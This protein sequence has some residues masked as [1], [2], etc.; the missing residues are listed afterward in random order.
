MMMFS[1]TITITRP[2][3]WH[4]HLRDGEP[5]SDVITFSAERFGRALVMP[6]LTPPVVTVEMATAYRN[7]ILTELHI[8]RL[9]K[10]F[11]PLMTLYLTDNTSP[12][13]IVEAKKSGFIH[14]V[15]Y[16][17]AGATT[18]STA[19]VTDICAIFPVLKKMEEIGMILC[20]HGEVTTPGVDVYEREMY[21]IGSVLFQL[22]DAFPN[23]RI[24]LEHITT[25]H[26]V[27]VVQKHGINLAATITA[28]HLLA[29]RN[30]MLANGIKPHFYCKPILK[31]Q[32]DQWALLQAATSG[33]P[34]FFL[35]TDSAPHSQRLKE[36]DCGCAG[37]FTAP[38]GIELYAEAFE[39][40][41]ALDTLEGFASHFG[42][43]FYGLP[44]NQ[45]TITLVRKPWT[46]PDHY[47]FGQD[48]V[49]PFGANEIMHW[50]LQS[51]K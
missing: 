2:D 13:E 3:D 14:A 29:N 32:E 39:T 46:I 51:V 6:N 31:T 19:G 4:L 16:C 8:A 38:A 50:K 1:N 25:A 49:V 42:A 24:V 12:E 7:R 20:L 34:K 45:D 22:L 47:P 21:F 37:C 15:K 11:H 18:N 40:M 17:P 27:R 44:R 33:N 5:M 43:D 35:G 10:K 41:N 23:L 26:A 9:E 36:N 28:H 48:V 30:D